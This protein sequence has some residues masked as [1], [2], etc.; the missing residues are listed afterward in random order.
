VQRRRPPEHQ[1]TAHGT[2]SERAIGYKYYV[3]YSTRYS[4]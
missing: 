1:G 3:V 2:A 4:T